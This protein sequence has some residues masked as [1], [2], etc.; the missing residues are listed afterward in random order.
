[1]FYKI[2]L[3][4]NIFVAIFTINLNIAIAENVTV[5]AKANVPFEIMDDGIREKA[6]E[7]FKKSALKRVTSKTLSAADKRM[8]AD[9]ENE[10]YSDP[11]AFIVEYVIIKERENPNKKIFSVAAKVEIDLETIK[12]FLI[13]NSEAGNMGS[14]MGSD[15]GLIV[16]ARKELSRTL[17]ED[18]KTNVSSNN[19]ISDIKENN[20]ATETTSVDQIATENMEISSEGGSTEIKSDLVN[21]SPSLALSSSA[22][23]GLNEQFTD[24]GFE[25]MD[26]ERVAY[27]NDVPLIEDLIR[28]NKINDDGTLS[29]R[30]LF[31]YQDLAENEFWTF[32]GYAILDVSVPKRI[33][34]E[35]VGVNASLRLEVWNAEDRFKVVAAVSDMTFEG[36]GTN[37]GSAE[38]DAIKLASR[39]AADI[40]LGQLR[41]KQLF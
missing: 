37:E 36:I 38:K 31:S 18:K 27:Q 8:L 15:F 10:F 2:I 41:A 16:M 19:A 22:T 1:M 30:D 35:T 21:F 24:S 4:L 13:T 25:L 23:S 40:V 34:S 7:E 12:N 14:G 3:F 28:E 17:F 5:S 20:A 6:I 32:L 29:K 26:V 33:N 39:A 9:L 11:D